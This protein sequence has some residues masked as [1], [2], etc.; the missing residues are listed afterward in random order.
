MAANDTT[1][2]V[3]IWVHKLFLFFKPIIKAFKLI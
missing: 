2:N 3:K 1:M